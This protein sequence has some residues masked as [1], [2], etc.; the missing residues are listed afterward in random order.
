MCVC[1][2]ADGGK[3]H[4]KIDLKPF[5]F[6]RLGL[7]PVNLSIVYCL[8]RGGGWILYRKKS[9]W[10]DSIFDVLI[11]STCFLN[12]PKESE[13]DLKE[14]SLTV[15]SDTPLFLPFTSISCLEEKIRGSQGKRGVERGRSLPIC[16]AWTWISGSHY[17]A[18]YKLILYMSSPPFYSLTLLTRRSIKSRV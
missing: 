12:H 5:K 18:V 16:L 9:C 14:K 15:S 10:L 11:D 2:G 3:R 13:R 4:R 7:A 6:I 1:V 8:S 17:T